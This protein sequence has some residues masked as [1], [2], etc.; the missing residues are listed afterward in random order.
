[1]T[2]T[3]LR[4]E[5][6]DNKER[7]RGRACLQNLHTIFFLQSSLQVFLE[8][9]SYSIMVEFLKRSRGNQ[10]FVSLEGCWVETFH[11]PNWG[12]GLKLQSLRYND[13]YQPLKSQQLGICF[14]EKSLSLM[15]KGHSTQDTPLPNRQSREIQ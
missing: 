7:V 10:F 15:K 12:A 13:K 9:V 3:Q 5:G 11:R 14:Q 2:T 1:M 4:V 8:Y 6:S